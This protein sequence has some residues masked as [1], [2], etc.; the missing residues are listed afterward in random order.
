LRGRSTRLTLRQPAVSVS[1]NNLLTYINK[2]IAAIR[3]IP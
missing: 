2:T 3:Q 1:S